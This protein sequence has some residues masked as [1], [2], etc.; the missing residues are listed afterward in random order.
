MVSRNQSVLVGV[1]VL[2][3]QTLG[4]D[5][6][7]STAEL[8]GGCADII[9]DTTLCTQGG[10][11]E[12]AA[13]VEAYPCGQVADIAVDDIKMNADRS[14]RCERHQLITDLTRIAA[15]IGEPMIGHCNILEEA[16]ERTGSPP[17][18]NKVSCGCLSM[19]P[20]DEMPGMMNCMIN[21]KFHGWQA[22]GLCQSIMQG[23]R[24][25]P[26][27]LE[28]GSW[29][30]ETERRLNLSVEEAEK[31]VNADPELLAAY[32]SL[33]KTHTE[34]RRQFVRDSTWKNVLTSGVLYH[35]NITEH[36][37]PGDETYESWQSGVCNA[38]CGL[39]DAPAAVAP[40]PIADMPTKLDGVTAIVDRAINGKK[41][42]AT[43]TA[44]TLVDNAGKMSRRERKKA[45]KA[46]KAAKRAAKVAAKRAKMANAADL[47]RRLD[48]AMQNLI[49]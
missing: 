32:E 20:H 12:C 34:R 38:T 11:C 27:L 41:D 14:R 23:R 24:R 9:Q 4:E 39:C 8:A 5:L 19:I 28:D 47:M 21:E 40:T 46:R 7:Q 26:E 17:K 37:K 16:I 2:F 44:T 43:N 35:T 6:A 18:D 48:E 36:T 25:M 30:A 45:K 29:D 1:A 15:R 13:Y 22:H 49:Q 33:E 10:H 42:Q 31:E 3:S